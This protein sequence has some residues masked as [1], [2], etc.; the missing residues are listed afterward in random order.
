MLSDR[1]KMLL[2][3]LIV[4]V[5]LATMFTSSSIIMSNA[6]MSTLRP[7]VNQLCRN[8]LSAKAACKASQNQNCRDADDAAYKCER[9]VRKAYQH[10]NFGGC[11]YEIKAV[12]L[13]KAEW[14]QVPDGAC[15]RECAG[16]TEQ[17]NQCVKKNVRNFFQWHGLQDDGTI[18]KK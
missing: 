18:K 11:P 10:I 4:C 9:A 17:M 13:C 15:Q 3:A 7:P 14:C 12:T 2:P 6:D 1:V 5:C 8:A 16:V